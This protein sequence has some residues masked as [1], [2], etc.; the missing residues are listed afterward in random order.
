MEPKLYFF[1]NEK[2][3]WFF[4]VFFNVSAGCEQSSI[5]LKTPPM[6]HFLQKS[7]FF[8]KSKIL[9]AKRLILT[10]KNR[11]S[12]RRTCRSGSALKNMFFSQLIHTLSPLNTF[13]ILKVFQTLL[14]RTKFFCIFMLAPLF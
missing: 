13:L 14:L 6:E 2:N 1:P 4:L 10:R 5:V 8:I 3:F 7:I 12:A 11:Y 9:R